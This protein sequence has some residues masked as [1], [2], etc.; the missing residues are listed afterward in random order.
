MFKKQFFNQKK[1]KSYRV[2]Q[3]ITKCGNLYKYWRKSNLTS[4]TRFYLNNDG[5]EYE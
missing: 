5:K 1:N 4:C 2:V 3:M